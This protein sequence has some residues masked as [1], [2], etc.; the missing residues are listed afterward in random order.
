MKMY[1]TLLKLANEVQGSLVE[2]G[3]G[4]GDTAKK[5]VDY[6][7]QGKIPKRN[8]WLYDSFKG[9][10]TPTP[11]DE[12][13][14]IQGDFKRPPQPAY[15][16][17]HMIRTQVHNII[18]FVEKTL[19]VS[20]T[21][22]PI[23]VLHC[24]LLTYKGT[25]HSLR[26]LYSRLAED[27]VIIVEGYEEYPGVRKAVN[28]FLAEKNLGRHL[29]IQQKYSYIVNRIDKKLEPTVKRGRTPSLT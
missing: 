20:Y 8:I 28:T 16:M 24:D 11:E 15:D 5:F 29:V 3:F 26:S 1:I 4:K 21:G 25:L 6:M 23:A 14:I 27:A 10:P 2:L 7:N 13:M 12:G 22:E 9:Y 17:V 18:G 19:P